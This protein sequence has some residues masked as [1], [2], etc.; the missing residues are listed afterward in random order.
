M[1]CSGRSHSFCKPSPFCKLSLFAFAVT[2]ITSGLA[3]GANGPMLTVASPGTNA[4]VGSPVYFEATAS[5][6]SCPFGLSAI[7][8]YT[9]P[10][11]SAFTTLGSHLETFLTLKAGTYNTVIQAWDNCGNV[12]KVARTIT[13]NSKAGVSVFLPAAGANTT[14]VHFAV[15]AQNPACPA[16]MSAVRIYPAPGVNAY[17]RFGPMLDAFLNLI[18]GTYGAVAQAWDNCGH[19]YKTPVTIKNT[20]GFP[21][22]FL[23]IADQNLSNIAQYTVTNGALS[24]P[25]GGPG[26]RTYSLPAK[27]NSAVVDPSGNFLYVGLGDGEVT[28]FEIN[29]ANGNLS[30]TG[31]VQEGGAQGPASIAMD[32]AG[33][34][35]FVAEYGSN[36][37]L[38]FQIDRNNGHLIF[39]NASTP[40]PTGTQPNEVVVDWTGRFVYVSNYKSATISAY[41]L[42]TNNGILNPIPGSPFPVG[43]LPTDLAAT[44]SNAYALGYS[45]LG[46]FGYSINGSNGALTT[47][48]G[49]PYSDP[50][51]TDA[52]NSLQADALHNL[53]FHTNVGFT[54]GTDSIQADEIQSNGSLE[55]GSIT[56][57]VF[58]PSSL[59]LDP[60]YK[61]FYVAQVNGYTG[62]PQILSFQYAATNGAGTL[63]SG[64]LSRPNDNAVQI[65]VSP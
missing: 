8:I 7:R 64:P 31:T 11:Q 23:Y 10:S 19:V 25:G 29:R 1:R 27:A 49:S 46:N 40:I 14:P 58:S 18:P 38:A 41:A 56:S 36:E 60:S 5:T 51:A 42:N 44:G 15:S 55:G 17:T 26:P 2:L 32:P 48:P 35:V 13:V 16:G 52:P 65:A 50:E 12:S 4:N 28:A 21:G 43:A 61:Y 62:D 39:T 63:L 45:D 33:N 9:A 53:L 47:T 34:Y 3:N 24:I 20:G 37:I 30:L 59:A 22:K 54:F 57:G 6:T